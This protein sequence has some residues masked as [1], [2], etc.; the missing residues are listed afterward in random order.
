MFAIIASLRIVYSVIASFLPLHIKLTHNT[1][2]SSKTG[3]ILAMF[4][5]STFV[6]SPYIGKVQHRYNKRNFIAFGYSLCLVSSAAFA[7]LDLDIEDD[8]FFLF[9]VI[10]RFLQG[11]G[12]ACAINAIYSASAYEFPDQRDMI[13]GLLEASY[14]VGFTL[15]PLIGQVLYAQYGFKTCFI[16][17][18]AILL[19]PMGFIWTMEF[20]K[21]DF[22]NKSRDRSVLGLDLTYGQLLMNKRTL[23]SLG[24]MYL[25][26][27]CMIFYEPLLTNQ[28]TS[29]DIGLNKIGYFFLFGTLSYVVFGPLVGAFSNRV[30]EKRYLML[31]A[32]ATTSLA[33]LFFGPSELFLLPQS[34]ELM[35]FGLI[36]TGLSMSLLIVPVIPELIKS[37]QEA[38]NIEETPSLCDKCSAMSLT[39]QSLGYIFGPIIGG[40]LYDRYGFRGTTDILMIVSVILS[41]MYY[42][43]VIRPLRIYRGDDLI[44]TTQD[45]QNKRLKDSEGYQYQE[46]TFAH[47]D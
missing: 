2:T 46:L 15:G 12:D 4:D 27:V 40:G 8:T 20:Q 11:L 25:C 23:W 13:F 33:L 10:L 29:M 34:V 45:L 17:V 37:S 43:L 9:A 32:F 18:S 30:S 19:I 42:L 24:S 38:L 39:S 31:A 5:I 26:I 21:E 41:M 44:M 3:F 35:C 47:E 16:V 7:L 6:C 36:L 28:L 14:G 1:I 22:T